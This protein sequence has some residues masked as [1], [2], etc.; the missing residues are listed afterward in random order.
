MA[1]K[2]ARRLTGRLILSAVACLLLTTRVGLAD[3]PHA[4]AHSHDHAASEAHSAENEHSHAHDDHGHGHGNTIHGEA[5][6][7]YF[8]PKTEFLYW[9]PQLFIWTLLL[10]LP[11]WFLL[12]RLVWVPM[13]KGWEERE[14]KMAES[15]A[16]A[17]KLRDEAK[18]LSAEQD[19]DV[20]RAQQEARSILDHAREETNQRVA[21]M[22]NQAK[23]AAAEQQKQARAEI[24]AAVQQGLAELS[25]QAERVGEDIARNLSGA[26]GSR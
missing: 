7:N 2:H 20:I 22:V 18:S 11:L 26:G 19:A 13:I 9:S 15:L 24:D 3:D 6:K 10:F 4:D 17:A 21:E 5:P 12:Q 1:D 8:G 23:D 25:H 14:Q 16:M